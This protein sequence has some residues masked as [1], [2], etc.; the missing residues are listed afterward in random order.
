MEAIKCI[1]SRRSIRKYK[2]KKIPANIIKQL[3]TAGMN[4]PSA[5]NSQPW[6]FILIKNKKTMQA[7]VDA[8]GGSQFITSA[9]LVIACC[10]DESKT[11]DKFHNIENVSLAA[12]NIL[13]AAHSLG[14]GA[15]YLGAFDPENP[16]VEKSISKALKLPK[17]IHLVCILSVGYPD[18]IPKSKKMRKYSEVIKNE[19]Y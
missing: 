4:A 15:C 5:Y 14:L 3:I 12:E 2:N 1:N 13:L 8:K 6:I 10:Y 19:H 11:P 16:K 9:P 18:E 7:I 17:N